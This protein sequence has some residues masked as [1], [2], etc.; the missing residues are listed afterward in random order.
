MEPQKMHWADHMKDSPFEQSHFTD[1]LRLRIRHRM[2]GKKPRLPYAAIILTVLAFSVLAFYLFNLGG[3]TSP[4]E[5]QAVERTAYYENDR[6]LFEVYP[7]PG[8]RAGRDYG[9]IFHFTAPFKEL[10]GKELAIYAVHLKTG[11][12]V[13]ALSPMPVTEPS[14]GYQGLERLT[15]QF[16][17]PLGGFWRYE[18][19]LDGGPYGN[20]VLDV[21]EPSWEV[22]ST[23]QSGRYTMMGV[24]KKAGF[25]HPGFI[26]GKGNKYMWHFWGDK[27]ELD[28]K[29]SIMAV[30]RGDEQLIP[31]FS[32][33]LGGPNNGAD[34]H[35]PST[36][37]LPQAGMWRLLLFID[38]KLFESIVVEVAEK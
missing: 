35:I 6:L 17:L 8:L 20:V 13:T 2:N 38:D 37:M 19:E 32:G 5:M 9:Y 27:S 1:E 28:G 14:S 36:M 18:V 21:G 25:I 33:K 15:V 7:D 3:W 31:V 24:E 34:R 4:P 23:F 11:L 12:R 30:K 22:S 16:Q 26:A 10:E 29:L